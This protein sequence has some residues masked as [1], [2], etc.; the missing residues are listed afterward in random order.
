MKSE[1]RVASDRLK[2]DASVTMA[3][4]TAISELRGQRPDD[5]DFCLADD[6]DPDALDALFAPWRDGAVELTL[7]IDGCEVTVRETGTEL[8]VVAR[9]GDRRSR[10]VVGR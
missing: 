1:P 5:M 9:D 10:T 6:V 4:V 2:T 3:V 7:S 8:S